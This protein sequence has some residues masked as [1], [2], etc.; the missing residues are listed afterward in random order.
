M[1]RG[2]LK[3]DSGAEGSLLAMDN[4]TGDVLAMVGGR[5]FNLSQFDRATQAERQTG[6]SFKPY[7]YTAAVEE[8]AK[9][10]EKIVDGPTSFGVLYAARLRGEL[11]G[12]HYITQGLC[13]F[14]K[15]PCAE[16][17]RTRRHP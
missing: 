10:Q 5:D 2:T 13:R 17:G 1:L 12:Q 7:V 6:S 16:A 4:A 15:Y 8:G 14:A 3:Q 11:P 9:P